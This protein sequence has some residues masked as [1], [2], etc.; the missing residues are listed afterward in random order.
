VRDEVGKRW[1]DAFEQ[2]ETEMKEKGEKIVWGLV[3]G[4][5]LYWNEVRHARVDD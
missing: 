1:K 2:L 5:L 3:D 4:F